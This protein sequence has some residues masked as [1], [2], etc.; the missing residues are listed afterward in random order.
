MRF[1]QL[2]LPGLA[3]ALFLFT[4]ISLIFGPSVAMPDPQEEYSLDPNPLRTAD[5]SSPRATLQSFLDNLGEVI[6]DQRR[7]QFSVKTGRAFLRGINTLDFST[8]PN[9][10]SWLVRTRRVLLLQELLGRI[11]LPPEQEIPGEKAVADGALTEWTIPNTAITIAIV[12]AGPREG[13]FLFSAD[14]VQRLHRFYEGVKDLPPKPGAVVGLYDQWLGADTGP[15]ALEEEVRNRLR[16]VDTSS[17]RSTMEGFLDSINR[18]YVLVTEA[19]AALRTTPPTLTKEEAR[20]IEVTASNLLQRAVRTLDLSEVPEALRDDIGIESILQLKEIFDR[21]QLPPVDTVP[22]TAMVAAARQQGNEALRWRYPNTE[23]EIVEVTEG[24]RQGEFLFSA[25]TV[26]RVSDFYQQ[27][28]SL[29]Y[30]EGLRTA[31]WVSPDKSEGFFKY[32]ISTPGHLIPQAHPFGKAMDALPPWLKT[33]HGQQTRWQWIGLVLSVLALA[34][35]AY[36]LFRVLRRIGQR[37][38]AP[39]NGWLIVLA[40]VVIALLASIIADFIDNDLNISGDLSNAIIAAG[41]L[42]VTVMGAWAFYLLS[43]ALAATIIAR[44]QWQ[45]RRSEAALLRISAITIGL[46][47]GVWIVVAGVRALGA[48]LIP[49]LAGL[50]VG[51]LAVALAAQT[52]IANFIG[53]LILFI[54]KPVRVGDFC[55]YG[56]DPAPGWWRIGWIEQIGWL[57][58]RVRGIDRTL[59]TIPNAEFSRM[60][61]VNLT[62]RD[63]RLFRT[64]LQLRYE[65]TPEQMRFVLTRLRELLLGHPMVTD[66]PARVRY[67]SLGTYSKDVDVYC[68]FACREESDFLAIQEDLLLRIEDIVNEAG[69]GF[70]FPSQTAYLARDTG[71]D[72][73]RGEEA[74]RDMQRRRATGKLPFPEFEDEERERLENI[75]DYPPKGSPDY[76]P[77][78]GSS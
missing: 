53:G 13:E 33:L 70:A 61:I 3:R 44:P 6:D 7:G 56:E 59:T 72:A 54:D 24:E 37:I 67:I 42:I 60:H 32:F 63:Q 55:R 30:R 47:G 21:I 50:G 28:E 22:D 71:L 19:D 74:E 41:R 18:A 11:E 65:T 20:A 2:P 75:L 1:V 62:E 35:V 69:T 31:Q 52:T 51:G 9:G 64:T 45:E 73:E 76:T 58:T 36:L 15:L 77:R 68:Y 27:V 49:I 29:P 10:D 48:E 8:T 26:R 46:M 12:Q 14:T 39:L 17:P 25:G 4:L 40:P 34:V 23:V 43:S 78:G 66:T 5:T 38:G 16:P 57:S